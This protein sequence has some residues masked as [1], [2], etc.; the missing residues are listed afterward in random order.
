MNWSLFWQL[1]ATAF[2]AFGGAWLAHA[3]AARRDRA[4]RRRDQRITFLIDAYRRLEYISNRPNLT[5]AQP[6]ESAVA[7]L[8][9]FGSSAQVEL[10]QAVINAFASNRNASMDRLLQELR[11]DLRAEL[12]LKAVP[13]RLLFL[14][15]NSKADSPT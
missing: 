5:D 12:G 2:V 7:D 3:L 14:R 8:Q 6:F 15:L 9:L 13:E 10:T 11:K 1:L 4:N